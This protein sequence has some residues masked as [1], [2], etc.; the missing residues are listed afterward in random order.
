MNHK[1]SGLQTLLR[2]DSQMILYDHPCRFVTW[3]STSLGNICWGFK[4]FLPHA[5]IK[6]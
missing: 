6:L 3:A 1:F 2:S 4:G 5:W